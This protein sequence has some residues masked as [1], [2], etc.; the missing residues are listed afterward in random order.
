M[1]KQISDKQCD[2]INSLLRQRGISFDDMVSNMPIAMH[3]HFDHCRHVEGLASWE[4]GKVIDI[5]VSEAGLSNTG[6]EQDLE[7][8]RGLRDRALAA[9]PIGPDAATLKARA[10]LAAKLEEMGYAD[11]DEATYDLGLEPIDIETIG[12][13]EAKELIER[14]AA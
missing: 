12:L 13:I 11:A 7:R 6:V 8:R 2:F 4:A 14:L 10:A 9:Q 5:L 3:R 1:A